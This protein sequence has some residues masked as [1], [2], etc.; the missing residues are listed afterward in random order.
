M[1]LKA[2]PLGGVTRVRTSSMTRRIWLIAGPTA[3][4]KSAL[5]L[6]LAEATGGEIVNADAL[7]LYADDEASVADLVSKR[8]AAA[9][10]V[11]SIYYYFGW[12]KAAFFQQ[13]TPPADTTD[14]RP[15]RTPVTVVSGI[16]LG[17]LAL[18]SIFIGFYQGPLGQW[19]TMK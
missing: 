11:I 18:A 10:V 14:P 3:S 2:P 6:R 15:A 16:T 19:L 12:I 5:A 17:C 4:G 8:L 13:W 1:T 9:G 7:Q